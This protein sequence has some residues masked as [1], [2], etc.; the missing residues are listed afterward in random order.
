M[1]LSEILAN[2]DEAKPSRAYCEKTPKSKMLY[3][4]M[5]NRGL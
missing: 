5:V 3:F 4:V 1:K 2:V